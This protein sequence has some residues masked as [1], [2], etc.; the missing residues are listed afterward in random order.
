MPEGGRRTSSNV[1]DKGHIYYLQIHFRRCSL[2]ARTAA[3]LTPAIFILMFS[4]GAGAVLAQTPSKTPA[5]TAAHPVPQGLE[6][7]WSGTLQAGEAGLH[8][9]LHV[10][11]DVDGSWKGTVDSLDQGVYGIEVTSLV[12]QQSKLKFEVSS[13]GASYEGTISADHQKIEGIWKQGQLALPLDF[14]RQA[15]GKGSKKP[16][17]AIASVEGV[18]QGAIEASGLRFRVQLT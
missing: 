11:K 6:G 10:S 14:H 4:G 12:R 9:V 17:D 2:K 5:H 18:W 3:L 15:P 16:A 1:F 13:V 8:L 7:S